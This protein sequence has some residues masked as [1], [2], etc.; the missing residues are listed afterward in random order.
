MHILVSSPRVLVWLEE[1][2]MDSFVSARH[3]LCIIIGIPVW[4]AH[5]GYV[6]YFIDCGFC[7][8]KSRDNSLVGPVHSTDRD[9]LTTHPGKT[10]LAFNQTR[11]PGLESG[12]NWSY[13]TRPRRSYWVDP[14]YNFKFYPT[15]PS[16]F[17]IMSADT[18]SIRADVA[19]T[20]LSLA[21]KFGGSYLCTMHAASKDRRINS[22]IFRVWFC[23]WTESNDLPTVILP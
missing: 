4:I 10:L 6:E 14:Q 2:G 13:S 9:W 15:R 3:M 1:S 16:G 23:L 18:E 19:G 7:L 21:R 8:W 20:V 22:G 17:F 5:V 12:T 11:V